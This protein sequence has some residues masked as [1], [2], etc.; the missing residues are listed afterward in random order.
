MFVFGLLH[1]QLLVRFLDGLVCRLSFDEPQTCELLYIEIQSHL[2]IV[3]TNHEPLVFGFRKDLQMHPAIHYLDHPSSF[4][5]WPRVIG[6][7]LAQD[8]GWLQT[9]HLGEHRNGCGTE[10]SRIGVH[11]QGGVFEG[12]AVVLYEISHGFGREVSNGNLVPIMWI[13]RSNFIGHCIY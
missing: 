11:F 5:R 4:R 2:I 13:T 1:P 7:Q 10:L 3:G 9:L 12:S 6:Q 8:S